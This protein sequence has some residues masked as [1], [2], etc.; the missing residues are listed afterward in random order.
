MKYEWRKEEKEIYLPKEIP[1]LVMVPKM[2]YITI[3]GKGNPNHEDFQ[4]RIEVL[5]PLA[6]AIKMMPKSGYTPVGYFDYTVYPLEGIWSLTEAGQKMKSLNKD[7]FLYT[8]MLRQP[9]FVTK[10]V[11]EKALTKVKNK[12]D[13]KLFDEVKFEELEDGLC[14]QLL[15]LGAYDDE[16]KSFAKLNQFIEDNNYERTT[17]MHKEIYLSDFRKVEVDKLKTVI[18]CFIKSK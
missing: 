13:N 11:F 10:E 18:R 9:D 16:P 6:Y 7:E 4:K 17:L 3:T 15:H 5:Y 8:I 12:S 1:T 14:V 2:K